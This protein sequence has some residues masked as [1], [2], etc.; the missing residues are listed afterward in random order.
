ML[1][2]PVT[3]NETKKNKAK[4]KRNPKETHQKNEKGKVKRMQRKT[5]PERDT[6]PPSKENAT[7][8]PALP[9]HLTVVA[10]GATHY[11][12]YIGWNNQLL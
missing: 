5:K 9:A 8:T 1:Q 6:E 12:V 10:E 11:G 2:A 3:Q 7:S 4:K